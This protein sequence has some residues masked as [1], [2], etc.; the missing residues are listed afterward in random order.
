MTAECKINVAIQAYF[1][2]PALPKQASFVQLLQGAARQ[3]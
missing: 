2:K 3:T 1:T